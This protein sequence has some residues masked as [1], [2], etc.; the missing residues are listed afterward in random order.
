MLVT[1]EDAG[2]DGSADVLSVLAPHPFLCILRLQACHQ[3]SGLKMLKSKYQLTLDDILTATDERM[4]RATRAVLPITINKSVSLVWTAVDSLIVP[5]PL[6][7]N[8]ITGVHRQVIYEERV[9]NSSSNSNS[10]SSSNKNTQKNREYVPEYQMGS[11]E[12]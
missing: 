6:S 10:S 12:C 2:P 9:S 5:R 1:S 11:N 3:Q 8:T 7:C 4:K